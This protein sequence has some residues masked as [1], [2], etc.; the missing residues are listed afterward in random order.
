MRL[1]QVMKC[2]PHRLVLQRLCAKHGI[3]ALQINSN[4]KDQC[5]PLFIYQHDN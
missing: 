4:C 2:I 3:D 5:D 1:L